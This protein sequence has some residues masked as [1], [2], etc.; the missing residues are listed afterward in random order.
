MI[1]DE[2]VRLRSIP[3]RMLDIVINEKAL[4]KIKL[5]FAPYK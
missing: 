1:N 5:S 4:I 2:I 3:I